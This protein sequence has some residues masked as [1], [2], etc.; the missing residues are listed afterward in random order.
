MAAAAGAKGSDMSDE[1]D[2]WFKSAFGVDL[3]TSLGKIADDPAAALGEAASAVLQVASGAAGTVVGAV[4]GAAGAAAGGAAKKIAGA[5]SGPSAAP[6]GGGTGSFPLGG[7][8][9]RGGKN[10]ANDVRAVQRALGIADD[11]QCGSQT[12]GAIEAFQRTIGQAKPDGRV[13]AGGATERALAGGAGGASAA[14]PAPV[15]A[16]DDSGSFLDRAVKGVKDLGGTIVKEAEE[17]F[18]AAKALGGKVVQGVEGGLSGGSLPFVDPSGGGASNSLLGLIE[19]Y[20]GELTFAEKSLGKKPLGKYFEFEAKVSGSVKFSGSKAGLDKPSKI[21]VEKGVLTFVEGVFSEG[22]ANFKTETG[23]G[24]KPNAT[25]AGR[26]LNIGGAVAFKTNL[27]PLTLEFATIEISLANFD[28][29]KGL[30]GPKLSA[31]TSR[32]LGY[33]K[34]IRGVELEGAIAVTLNGELT[35]DYVGIAADVA[36]NAFAE[37]G[38]SAAISMAI[39]VALVA[40]P[41]LAAAAVIGI[42]IF[43]AG[44]KGKRDAA[45]IEGAIDAR[46]AAQDYAFV[47]TGSDVPGSGPRAKAAVA[48]ARGQLAKVAASQKVSVEDLMTEL[49]ADKNQEAD[50]ARIKAQARQQIFSAYFG[51]VR[52]HLKKW[53]EEHSVLAAFTTEADDFIAVEKLV[54]I[55]FQKS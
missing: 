25:K 27:G 4:V 9:G 5:V 43:M 42:G 41:P 30:S 35:P 8:V 36:R 29:K 12:I 16:G 39:D 53:R 6:A 15:Q 7:S 18:D 2:S 10:A 37:G 19:S 26:G 24:I 20:G 51:E 14:A 1:H 48:V 38:T 46:E 17:D 40:G 54:A 44:E 22:I 33:K 13:D 11:G 45:I 52:S 32:S 31:G 23:T 28:P 3:G 49:R 55:Q 21:D 47:M 50:F 34:T